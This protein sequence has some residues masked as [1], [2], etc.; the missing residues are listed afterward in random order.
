MTHDRWSPSARTPHLTLVLPRHALDRCLAADAARFHLWHGGAV[1]QAQSG[2]CLGVQVWTGPLHEGPPLRLPATRWRQ[3]DAQP[4]QAGAQ[5]LLQPPMP[6]AFVLLA[7]AAPG[8]EPPG[9]VATAGAALWDH[10]LARQ[11]PEFRLATPA[12][13]PDVAVLWL[14]PRDGLLRALL[15]T[16]QGWQAAAGEAAAASTW[17][18]FDELRLP[19]AEQQVLP[20][21]VPLHTPVSDALDALD[22]ESR[23]SRQAGALGPAVLHRLQRCR[24]GLV[25]GGRVG[26]ML[27]NS[28]ARMGCSLCVL[29]PDTMSP[30]SLDGDLP[31]VHEGQLKV[32]ALRRQLQGLMRP[33]ATLDLRPL[34]VSS[35]AAGAVLAGVDL[36][37]CAADNDAAALWADAWGLATHKPRLVLGSGLHPHG[38]EA[39]LR[40]LL[41]GAGC[42]CCTGGFSQLD[43]LSDQLGLSGPVPTPSDWRR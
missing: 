9:E 25:G 26:S 28:S 42:L 20:L 2:Q 31:A 23:F 39:D 43:E 24:I 12:L 30:H 1:I 14:R 22:A 6:R 18:P 40:L 33:G 29:D 10:W 8:D 38:A 36:I 17:L 35:P 11:A 16:G 19:G 7:L 15:R 32:T 37:V 41:P 34:S 13:R 5:G 3:G 27:A 21:R 4:L